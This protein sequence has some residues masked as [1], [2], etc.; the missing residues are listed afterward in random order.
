M[1]DAIPDEVLA[2]VFTHVEP[3]TLLVIPAVCRRWSRVCREEMPPVDLVFSR[4]LH[5]NAN[6][7]AACTVICR[8]LGRFRLVRS[9][10]LS[11]RDNLSAAGLA[12]IVSHCP[13]LTSLHVAECY[14][15]GPEATVITKFRALESLNFRV[16]IIRASYHVNAV[17]ETIAAGCPMLTSLRLDGQAH[18]TDIGLGK[19]AAGCFSK[20]LQ[21]LTC[22]GCTEVTDTGLGSIAAGCPALTLVTYGD[23]EKVTGLGLEKI[24]AGCPSLRGIVISC[25]TEAGLEKLVAGCPMLTT[26]DANGCAG[27]TDATL[28]KIAAAWP[29]LSVLT[30][31]GCKNVTDAGLEKIAASC[32]LLST[33]SVSFCGEVTDAGIASIAG[34]CSALT[35]LNLMDC[36]KVTDAG[37]EKLAAGCRALQVIDLYNNPNVTDTGLAILAAGCLS[38]VD[39]DVG[40]CSNVTKAGW[41]QFRANT[42]T[43]YVV[44]PSGNSGLALID[45]VRVGGDDGLTHLG[46]EDIFEIVLDLQ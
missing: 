12:L 18:L 43:T 6:D 32:S 24:A 23:C 14:I 37:L 34:G 46:F 42:V 29:A 15:C 41:S 10:D 3:W 27:V 36:E 33:L 4:M 30:I 1:L 25:M 11:G 44:R 17:L 9:I 13:N 45:A 16:I 38:L 40:G 20:T 2:M 22:T 28:A 31:S 26:I 8:L 5:T 21:E 35:F 39:V 7:D 19:I